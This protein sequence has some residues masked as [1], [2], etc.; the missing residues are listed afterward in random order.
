MLKL[1]EYSIK[2]Y[3]NALENLDIGGFY[4]ELAKSTQKTI[5]SEVRKKTP[6]GETGNLR[7]SWSTDR[8]RKNNDVEIH[9]LNPMKYASYVENGHRVG[10]SGYVE[11]RHMLKNTL[12]SVEGDFQ[13]VAGKKLKKFLESKL[14]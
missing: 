1:K 12:D 10:K 2:D 3:I 11:G 5:L 4:D 8:I 7:R 6:V 13:S 9:I 14:G